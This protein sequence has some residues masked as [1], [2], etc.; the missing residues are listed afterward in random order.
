MRGE[1]HDASMT[2]REDLTAEW[3]V[4]CRACECMDFI[5]WVESSMLERPYLS[6]EQMR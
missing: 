1:T 5:D 4:P 2:E 3:I 6:C